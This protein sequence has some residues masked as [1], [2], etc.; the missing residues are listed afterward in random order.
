GDGTKLAATEGAAFS[1]TVA[2]F[3]SSDTA[4]LAGTF[5]AAIDW[6][7]GS[8]SAGTVVSN[9]DGGFNV[10]GSHTYAEEAATETIHV[11]VSDSSS[12]SITHN[13]SAKVNDAA[14]S[15]T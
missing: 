9:G 4:A 14:L 11:A 1:G 2:A 13:A 12:H 8:T 7:D 10:L 5:A 15:A 3:A 6:G